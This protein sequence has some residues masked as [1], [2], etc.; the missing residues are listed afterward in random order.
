VAKA[1][2]KNAV[3]ERRPPVF[4]SRY[5]LPVKKK[6]GSRRESDLGGKILW[7]TGGKKRIILK[8]KKF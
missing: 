1:E 4:A 2:V 8:R 3:P 5:S 6:G 7:K